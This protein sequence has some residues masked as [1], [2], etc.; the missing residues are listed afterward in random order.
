MV[1]ARACRA[2]HSEAQL[3]LWFALA[4]AQVVLLGT[5]VARSRR[6]LRIGEERR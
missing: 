2:G 3:R 5:I 6:T 4:V 1:G